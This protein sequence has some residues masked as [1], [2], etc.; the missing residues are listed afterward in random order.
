MQNIDNDNNNSNSKSKKDPPWLNERYRPKLPEGYTS[1]GEDEQTHR[2]LLRCMQQ[3]YLAEQEAKL[4]PKRQEEEQRKREEALKLQAERKLKEKE[5][6]LEANRKKP[7]QQAMMILN[8]ERHT[9]RY[10][11]VKQYAEFYGHVKTC[12]ANTGR[13]IEPGLMLLANEY[14]IGKLIRLDE[15]THRRFVEF[16]ID[17]EKPQDTVNRLL[18]IATTATAA[19]TTANS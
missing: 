10:C 3:N 2:Y 9:C 16:R 8:D 14:R 4:A 5:Q 1:W 18:D 19:A 7:E 17:G 15:Q 13:S 11:H 6:R 12:P